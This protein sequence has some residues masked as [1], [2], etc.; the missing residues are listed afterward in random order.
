MNLGL[1]VSSEAAAHLTGGVEIVSDSPVSAAR[2]LLE[3][4]VRENEGR[5]RRVVF[6]LNGWRDSEDLVQEVFVRAF[7][8]MGKF[9]GRAAVSTWLTAV[10]VNV[11]RAERRKRVFREAFW[12]RWRAEEPMGQLD[13]E[14]GERGER[15][16]AAVRALP[17]KVRE[18]VVLRY[19]EEMDLDAVAAAVGISKGTVEVR[20][21]R[22]RAMLAERL[23]DLREDLR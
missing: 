22:G 8:G 10:A 21:H 19:L 3:A 4:L 6:R 11:C 16:V 23:G 9:E 1:P 13:V 18:V 17:G 12:R 20:L 15:V 14:A 7:E 5:V 2:P